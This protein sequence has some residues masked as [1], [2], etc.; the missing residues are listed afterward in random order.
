MEKGEE[1][2]SSGDVRLWELQTCPGFFQALQIQ[3]GLGPCNLFFP[4]D[5]IPK[6]PLNKPQLHLSKFILV[7]YLRST[8]ISV[9]LWLSQQREKA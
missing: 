2:L 1:R 3:T 8:K 4:P 6:W 9:S 7:R 5:E